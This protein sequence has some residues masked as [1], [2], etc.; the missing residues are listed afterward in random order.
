MGSWTVSLSLD[1]RV[2]I[3]VTLREIKCRSLRIVAPSSGPPY[4]DIASEAVEPQQDEAYREMDLVMDCYYT[5]K[6]VVPPN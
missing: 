1:G 6:P 2:R 4:M 3:T 5:S